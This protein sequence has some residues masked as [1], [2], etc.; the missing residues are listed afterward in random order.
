MQARR[1]ACQLA[2]RVLLAKFPEGHPEIFSDVM[3]AALDLAPVVGKRQAAAAASEQWLPG[4]DSAHADSAPAHS[5]LA[6]LKPERVETSLE[7]LMELVV[8]SSILELDCLLLLLAHAAL[9]PPA[10]RQR[11]TCHWVLQL[12]AVRLGYSGRDA[13]LGF[14]MPALAFGW[15]QVSGRQTQ[16]ATQLLA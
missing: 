9:T 7:L 10:P 2:P 12:V 14:H 16:P 1:V 13:L 8:N 5:A 4:S 15:M 3:E 6:E 11:M